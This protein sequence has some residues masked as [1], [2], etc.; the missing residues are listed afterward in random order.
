[1]NIEDPYLADDLKDFITSTKAYFKNNP[2]LVKTDT[3]FNKWY[4]QT[5][6]G[7]DLIEKESKHVENLIERI[8]NIEE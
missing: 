5:F 1:M 4:F 3:Q 2:D 8:I 6:F 7:H